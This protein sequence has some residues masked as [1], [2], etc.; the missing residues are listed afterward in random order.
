[1][2]FNIY[3]EVIFQ[4]ALEDAEDGIEIN[5]TLVNNLR[6]ADD[7]VIISESTE[8]LQRFLNKISAEGNLV[9]RKVNTLKT[10]HSTDVMDRFFKKNKLI[11]LH[12]SE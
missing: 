10:K 8:E 3:S 12:F 1:M 9:G 5:G 4:N 11:V 6:Y 2:L 7:T